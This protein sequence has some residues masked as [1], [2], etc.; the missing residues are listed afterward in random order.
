MHAAKDSPWC[1]SGEPLAPTFFS[2]IGEA[3]AKQCFSLCSTE[4]PSQI[5]NEPE[6]HATQRTGPPGEPLQSRPQKRL[7]PLVPASPLVLQLC[8]CWTGFPHAWRTIFCNP[9]DPIAL[10]DDSTFFAVTKHQWRAC[11]RRLPRGKLACVLPPSSLDSRSASGAFAVAKD[12]NRDRF[13]GDRRRL[14]TSERSTGRAQLPYCPRLRRMILD[15]SETVHI[16]FGDTKDCFY[17]YEVPPSRV[18]KHVIG[19]RD[20][21]KL[22]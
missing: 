14:N 19:P 6:F 7:S 22:A 5:Q 9:E 12:E 18:T 10:G 4:Q 1:R 11:V 15:K 21:S 3:G 8:H 13:T 20:S 2:V 16:T 17:L